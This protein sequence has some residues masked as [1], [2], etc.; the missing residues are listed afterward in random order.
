MNVYNE[1]SKNDVST[2]DQVSLESRALIRTASALN[3]IKENWEEKKSELSAALD[4][5]RLLWTIIATSMNEK[6]SPQPLN[7]RNNILNLALFVFQ[8]TVS[9]L[10]EPSPE[11]LDIL[12]NINMNI[13]KGLSEH[14]PDGEAPQPEQPAAQVEAQQPN[15]D[16]HVV[17]EDV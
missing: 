7:I 5:N 15:P 10:A 2:M 6:D 16:E 4:K 3:A 17:I 13:A 12:I 9:V 14:N 8:R 11:K 1:Y